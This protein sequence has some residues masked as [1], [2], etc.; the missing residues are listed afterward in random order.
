MLNKKDWRQDKT[1][2]KYK[3]YLEKRREAMEKKHRER[4]EKLNKKPPLKKVEDD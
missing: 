4:L 2:L 1:T 3:R